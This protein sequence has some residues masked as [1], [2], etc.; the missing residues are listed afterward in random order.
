[1][2]LTILKLG[3]LTK[4]THI[5]PRKFLVITLLLSGTLAWFFFSFSWL[6][7]F[8]KRIAPDIIWLYVANAL[9]FAAA[10][11][12]ALVGAV[13]SHR[14][15]RRNL[16]GSWIAL[17]VISSFALFFM[18]GPF[19]VVIASILLGASLGL[20]YPACLAFFAEATVPEERARVAGSVF[21][22]SFVL[23]LISQVVLSTSGL[24]VVGAIIICAFLR[25]SS[26]AA[27]T[28]DSC[29]EEK[30]V[31]NIK[32]SVLKRRNFLLY[33]IP[34]LIF[35]IANGLI[36]FVVLGFYTD[37]NYSGSINAGTPIHMLAAGLFALVGG[38]TADRIGRRQPVMFGLILL[39]VSFALL[40][41]FTSPTTLF[42]YFVVSGAAWGFLMTLY[43]AIPGDLSGAGFREKYYA[44]ATVIPLLMYMS[45]TTASNFFRVSVAAGTL[46]NVLS[47]LLFFSVIPVLRAAESLSE[48][49]MRERELREHMEKIEEL[50]KESSEKES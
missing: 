15:N 29:S 4:G 50:L 3:I 19:F 11:A 18:Q 9:Y 42:I 36:A 27:L 48:N 44:I 30:V 31:G 45:L 21:F 17:G 46:S 38:L 6:D 24:G 1:M 13:I 32:M 34:W 41:V 33:V 22:I 49:R 35:N 14:I 2:L 25:L 8:I 10:G 26:F 23:V 20:G 47:I 40:G 43:T 5:S 28:L 39:G 12:S 37:L 7:V 16:L